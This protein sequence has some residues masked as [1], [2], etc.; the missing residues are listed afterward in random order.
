MK[1][2][3][4]IPVFNEEKYIANCL[5]TL[6]NQEEPADEIIIVDNNS[7]D[8][9]A[10]IVKKYPV[11]LTH[12]KKQGMIPAR[13]HGFNLAKYEIIARTDADSRLPRTW[14]KQIKSH[15]LN[16][17][18]DALSGTLLYYDLL[19]PTTLFANIFFRYLNKTQGFDTLAGPNLAITKKM[20]NKIKN[21]CCQDERLVHEDI[22]LAWHVHQ[23][24]GITKMDYSLIIQISA[25]RIK[26][27]P[28]SFFVEYPIRLRS[29][30]RMHQP[31]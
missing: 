4:V 14:I 3:V 24:G 10:W 13:N 5:D 31:R 23:A 30:Q 9:T 7:T 1:I 2:S 25:R 20:W 15:F 18:I 21:T 28:L 6:V 16:Q 26:Y 8:R 19:F 27:N 29:T 11:I 22:D 17:S 12:E